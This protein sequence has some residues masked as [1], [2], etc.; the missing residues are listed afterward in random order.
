MLLRD[1]VTKAVGIMLRLI[2]LLHS[3]QAE[4]VGNFN[5][6]PC[7][8]RAAACH[9]LLYPCYWVLTADKNKLFCE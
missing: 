7:V 9:S 2:L 3:E 1:K 6:N 4:I 8:L 5:L